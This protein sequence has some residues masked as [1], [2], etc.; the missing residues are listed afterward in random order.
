M[1]DLFNGDI[2]QPFDYDNQKKTHTSTKKYTI[3]NREGLLNRGKYK[4]KEIYEVPEYYKA[5]ML[6]TWDLTEAD[7]EAIETDNVEIKK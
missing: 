6:K 4:G 2:P 7:E 5:Y 1:T 3:F